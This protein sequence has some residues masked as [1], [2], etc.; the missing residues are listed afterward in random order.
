M[1]DPETGFRVVTSSTFL[2]RVAETS[3][4]HAANGHAT[5]PGDLFSDFDDAHEAEL[6]DEPIVAP[7][8]DMDAEAAVLSAMFMDN[9]AIPVVREYLRPEGFFAERHQ[10]IARAIFDLH[11]DG[12]PVDTLTVASR[13]R[14]LERIAQVGGMPYITEVINA[15]PAVRNV[16]TYAKIVSSLAIQ[17]DIIATCKVA[18]AGLSNRRTDVHLVLDSLRAQIEIVDAPRDNIINSTE[19]I[20]E[21]LPPVPYL[22]EGLG[23]APGAP[24]LVAGYGYSG[25]TLSIQSLGVS[26]A[27][28]RDLWDRYPVR[29]GRVL[30]IDYEQGKRLTNERYQRICAAAHIEKDYLA[31]RLETMILPSLTFDND[32]ASSTLSRLGDGRALVIIDSFRA[33]AP[34][35]DENSSEVRVVLDA[36]TRASEKTGCVF[37]FIHHARKPPTEG[38]TGGAKYSLRGSGAFFDA[39]GS[40]FV[41]VGEKGDPVTAEH[42]KC[43]TRGVTEDTFELE[44]ADVDGP[45]GPRNGVRVTMRDSEEIQSSKVAK[46][47]AKELARAAEMTKRRE[48]ARARAAED[49]AVTEATR[50]VK[51]QTQAQLDDEA[52]LQVV[53]DK[54]GL[55]VT[56]LRIE[57]AIRRG[58]CGRGR[59]EEALARQA[60]RIRV[61][62]GEKNA[63]QHFLAIGDLRQALDAIRDPDGTGRT[64]VTHGMTGEPLRP[65]GNWAEAAEVSAKIE[66]G[67]DGTGEQ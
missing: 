59:V 65:V 40:V 57:M 35:L 46:E 63:R 20:F 27:S 39:A 48:E 43:R 50:T 17:R 19:S 15:A 44:I 2:A 52:L 36:A 18:V 22:V 11:D 3:E 33:C 42:E 26:V 31:G 23:V 58:E 4:P 38:R 41:F 16:A 14:M 29:A 13:L 6:A 55:P 54:P 64:V 9:A 21:E 8:N 28:G 5:A 32:A 66:D 34:S 1:N 45:K 49:A 30:H 25:K 60:G 67:T 7:P 47:S 53:A 56:A 62:V 12:I 10:Y 24:V 51:R 37:L 61:A